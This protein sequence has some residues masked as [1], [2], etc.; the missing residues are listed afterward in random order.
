[1][2]KI[3]NPA[4]PAGFDPDGNY[5]NMTVGAATKAT[6]DGQGRDIAS[7]YALKSEAK[8]YYTHVIHVKFSANPDEFIIKFD[9]PYNK[10][11]TQVSSFYYSIYQS[12]TSVNTAYPI[13]VKDNNEYVNGVVYA[14]KQDGYDALTFYYSGSSVTYKTNAVSSIRDVVIDWQ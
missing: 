12:A 8:K 5:P 7:T 11:L 13:V 10:S 14:A 2:Q 4:S 6:Q 3:K 9:S 1:M